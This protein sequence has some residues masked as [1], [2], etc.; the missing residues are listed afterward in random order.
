MRMQNQQHWLQEAIEGTHADKAYEQVTAICDSY[1]HRCL[2]AAAIWGGYF[3]HREQ[4]NLPKYLGD[5][6]EFAHPNYHLQTFHHSPC[7][8]SAFA[9]Q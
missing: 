2:C 3:A 4:N 6:S 7:M 9:S 8:I 1:A 5:E